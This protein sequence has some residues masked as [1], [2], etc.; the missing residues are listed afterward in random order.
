MIKYLLSVVLL[1]LTLYPLR[2]AEKF[3]CAQI[4][5][6]VEKLGAETIISIAQ[7]RGATKEQIMAVIARCRL[8]K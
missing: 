5:L 7:A 3:T 4:R 1:L 8:N 2:A 6:A